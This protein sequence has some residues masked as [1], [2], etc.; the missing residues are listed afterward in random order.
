M[1]VRGVRLT[2]DLSVVRDVYV[3]GILDVSD[4]RDESRLRPSRNFPVTTLC[5]IRTSR[6]YEFSY[7][8]VK[9]RSLGP[10]RGLLHYFSS[11]SGP[12]Q[13]LSRVV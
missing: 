2:D 10:F 1:N 12:R 4:L 7:G 5:C 9:V 13:V 11:S 6:S 3:Q 8:P